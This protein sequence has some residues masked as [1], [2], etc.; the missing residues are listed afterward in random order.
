MVAFPIITVYW[1][2]NERDD[3]AEKLGAIRLENSKDAKR[4]R[5]VHV[6][7]R[8]NGNLLD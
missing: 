1:E 8:H 7:Q 6:A 3:R 5:V 2:E 4:P